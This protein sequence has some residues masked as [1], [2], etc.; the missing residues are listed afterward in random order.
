MKIEAIE[1]AKGIATVAWIAACITAAT[2][3]VT[4]VTTLALIGFYVFIFAAA[5]TAALICASVNDSN[6]KEE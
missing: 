3:V 6:L 4:G 5:A 2:L 1:A